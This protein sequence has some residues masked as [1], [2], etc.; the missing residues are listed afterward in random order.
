MNNSNAI[1]N[2]KYESPKLES[3]ILSVERGYELSSTLENMYGTED[4]WD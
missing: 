1:D 4:D 3:V 2:R